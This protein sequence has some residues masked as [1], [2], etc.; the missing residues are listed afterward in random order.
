MIA[1]M[2]SELARITNLEP[3]VLNGFLVTLHHRRTQK[4]HWHYFRVH[5]ESGVFSWRYVNEYTLYEDG[6]NDVLSYD[7]A[8]R[9]VIRFVLSRRHQFE[10]RYCEW[11]AKRMLT[12]NPRARYCN[13]RCKVNAYYHRRKQRESGLAR[14]L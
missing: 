11:C 4:I 14:V 6:Y 9:G 8:V 10:A 2:K 13:E 1:R 7:D 3:V 12:H 5:T